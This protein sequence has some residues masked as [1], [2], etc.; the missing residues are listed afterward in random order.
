VYTAEATDSDYG[1]DGNVQYEIT[2]QT[3]DGY[4]EIDSAT[5]RITVA[6]ELDR[7]TTPQGISMTIQATDSPSSGASR[8]TT[9]TLNI[10]ISD[11]NDN[12]PQ[13]SAVPEQTVSENAEIGDV[14]VTIEATDVDEG[15]NADITYSITTASSL[16]EIDSGTGEIK[17]KASLDLE[18]GN[19]NSDFRYTL[20]VE[21]RDGGTPSNAAEIQ[22]TIQIT[23]ENEFDPTFDKTTDV[24]SVQENTTI[25]TVVYTPVASDQDQSTDGELEFTLVDKNGES[26]FSINSSSGD[27]SVAKQ[28]DYTATP[29]G[30][31]LT[32]TATDKPL[33][34]STAKTASLDLTINVIYVGNTA[35]IFPETLDTT[36]AEDHEVDSV[37]LTIDITD[38]NPGP[39]GEVWFSIEDGNALGFF[40]ID[41]NSGDII[42]NKSLDLETP[43][44]PLSQTLTIKAT[45]GGTPPL[46]STKTLTIT[47]TSV[48]EF[49]PQFNVT[50]DTTSVGEEVPVSTKV[51]QAMASDLDYGNDGEVVFSIT[52]GNEAGYFEIDEN[53]GSVTTAAILDREAYPSGIDLV[54]LIEDKAE[55]GSRKNATMSLHIDISDFNDNTPVFTQFI[56]EHDVSEAAS[57]GHNIVQVQANDADLG[58]NA[59]IT[60]S[61]KEG[62][63]LGYFEIDSETGHV[64]VLRSLDLDAETQTHSEDLKYTLIIQAEDN[65]TPS[66]TNTTTVEITI[67]SENEFTPQ[68]ADSSDTIEVSEDTDEPTEV[69]NALAT[70]GDY[71]RDG[72]IEY[73]IISQSHVGYFDIDPQSG[74]VTVAQSVDRETIP[75]GIT[76][77][78]QA[79]DQPDIGTVK[80]ATMVLQIEITDVN[81]QDPVFTLP[82]SGQTVPEDASVNT[83]ITQLEATDQ[84]LGDNAKISYSI[85]GGNSLGFFDI[86]TDSGEVTVVKSLDLETETHAAGLSYTLVITATDSGV[87]ARSSSESLSIT[88]TSVN[89]FSPQFETAVEY[90]IVAHNTPVSQVVYDAEA[91]D[92]DFGVDGELQ[93]A[94]SSSNNNGYFTIDQSNGE[95]SVAKVLDYTAVPD[96]INIT[97]TA[98]DKAGIP[99]SGTMQLNIEVQYVANSAPVFSES[100]P[101]DVSIGED[102]TVDT[103]VVNVSATDFDPGVKGEIHYSI[104]SGNDREFF[105]IN[106][107]T[108]AL[109][110]KESLDLETKSHAPD[111]R[112]VLIIQ[113]QDGGTPALSATK[114]VNVQV[115][116][117]NEFTPSIS[118]LITP[119]VLKEDTPRNTAVVQVTGRDEDFGDDGRL[120]YTISGGNEGQYFDINQTTGILQTF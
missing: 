33:D 67:I 37:I 72:Q 105:K 102:A 100:I 41:R 15:V 38:A 110:V 90:R 73:T 104:S 84:D 98:T 61:I 95:I 10:S 26:Y 48:N 111:A 89:E 115:N 62:N 108:G 96:G 112:Y 5:G 25:S 1:N 7:E 103:V 21:A 31:N 97:I 20:T 22:V 74:A 32:I 86:N 101:N 55:E 91:T 109:M 43:S 34:P 66:R 78:I 116:A 60:Y 19:H 113:A 119:Q 56:P 57:L 4:F 75:D 77:T 40:R 79:A 69:Y 50:S 27:V 45:D 16:F 53:N 9:M 117:V 59:D 28:L 18:S 70:D 12:P 51:Y 68:F 92:Q 85:T 44:N 46:S 3:P 63:S 35:P 58:E 106:E 114:Q 39:N 65:G 14:I 52:S 54:L 49:T 36:V 99:K 2:N 11:Y 94:M 118:N 64:K 82:I 24:I 47:V 88:V 17:V 120:T 13:L 71:G 29:H 23:G 8:S 83:L 6:Q 87:P 93:Y 30:I 81:D 107:D 80:T 42:L 76:L